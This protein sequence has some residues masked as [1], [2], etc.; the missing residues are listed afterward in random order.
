M[1]LLRAVSLCALVIAAGPAA[2]E[3]IV[4]KA[5]RL[6]DGTGRATAPAVVVVEG[7]RI[8]A[9]GATASVPAGAR[10]IDLGDATL[11]PGLIDLHT[12][13][14]GKPTI[15]WEDELLRSNPAEAALW[16]AHNAR[17][18]LMAGFTTTRDM[19][20]TWPYVD[21]ALRKAI[22]EGAVPGPRLVVAGNYVSATGGAGDARQFS[23]YV[24]V[25]TVQNLADGAPEI[26]KAVRTNL[27]QGADF[28]KILVTGA[29]LSKGLPPGAQ[30]YSQAEIEAAVNEARRWGRQVAAHAHGADG[31]KAAIRA[32]VRTVD[33]GSYLDDEAVALLKAS[34]RK[35]FYVPTLYTNDAILNGEGAKIPDSEVERARRIREIA[36]GAFRR[37]LAAGIPI[38]FATDSSVIPHGKNA[39]EMTIRVG[40][41]ESPMAAIVSATSLNA[42]ILGWSDR[43][44]S[45]EKG[46]LADLVAVSGDPLK[47]ITEMERVRFVMKDG[48]VYRN[49][50]PER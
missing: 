29:V 25:P 50:E 34:G 45:V 22:E 12:H 19:G 15:H 42:E 3:T 8:E 48:V 49:D 26:V 2:A 23:I 17:I 27:K 4:L 41:G 6:I 38:G 35:T 28:I 16:G 13:L 40:L 43:I 9:V 7:E 39:H 33:H 37:A 10:V 24:D 44:G 46:K 47:D 11:L 1:S 20:P 30:Q 18:T 21:V 14:C 31:I 32:G 36:F 5:S